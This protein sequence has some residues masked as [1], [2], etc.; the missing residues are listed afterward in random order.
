MQ[1]AQSGRKGHETLAHELRSNSFGHARD[2]RSRLTPGLRPGRQACRRRRR[3]RAGCPGTQR[4][5]LGCV[6]LVIGLR[7]GSG[8]LAAVLGP[9][10]PCNPRH[11]RVPRLPCFATS[12]RVLLGQGWC[13]ATPPFQRSDGHPIPPRISTTSPDAASWG[14]WNGNDGQRAT[15]AAAWSP[16]R[17]WMLSLPPQMRHYGKLSGSVHNDLDSGGVRGKMSVVQFYFRAPAL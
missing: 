17:S 10:V 6:A 9:T 12:H 14:R 11:A 3:G 1:H 2:G 15:A 4:A 5:G 16:L 7:F 13:V 8:D